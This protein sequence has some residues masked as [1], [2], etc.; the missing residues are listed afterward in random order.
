MMNDTFKNAVCKDLQV[1]QAGVS[2]YSCGMLL[3]LADGIVRNV[4]L[5]SGQKLEQNGENIREIG[6]QLGIEFVQDLELFFEVCHRSDSGAAVDL[7]SVNSAL[8][9]MYELLKWAQIGIGKEQYLSTNRPKV[10]IPKENKSAESGGSTEGSVKPVVKEVVE[11][12]R[13]KPAEV[14]S[15]VQSIE[16]KI[17]AKEVQKMDETDRFKTVVQQRAESAR[18]DSKRSPEHFKIIPA[19]GFEGGC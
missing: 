4:I 15:A 12:V 17:P 3:R 14:P 11:E 10:V 18:S 2:R 7:D 1:L 9:C 16:V 5:G 6:D 19:G 13:E 8:S